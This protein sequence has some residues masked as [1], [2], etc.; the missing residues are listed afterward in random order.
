MLSGAIS[1]ICGGGC[2]GA[3]RKR[4]VVVGNRTNNKKPACL[5]VCECVSVCA[6][7]RADRE[8]AV[9]SSSAI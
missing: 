3:N 1:R 4:L 2:D 8:G 9:N 5:Q 6:C 7:V